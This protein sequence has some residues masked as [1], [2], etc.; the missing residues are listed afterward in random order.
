MV[1]KII[2]IFSKA[3]M[4]EITFSLSSYFLESIF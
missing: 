4:I 3:T 2:I 1:R